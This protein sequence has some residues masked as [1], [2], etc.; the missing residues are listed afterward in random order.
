M[1]GDNLDPELESGAVLLF[2]DVDGGKFDRAVGKLGCVASSRF[3]PIN[4]RLGKEKKKITWI[5]ATRRAAHWPRMPV[6]SPSRSSSE[7]DAM[8]GGPLCFVLRFNAGRELNKSIMCMR[9]E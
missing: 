1:G 4:K 9:G 5:A 8:P 7:S 2:P 6:T 3:N